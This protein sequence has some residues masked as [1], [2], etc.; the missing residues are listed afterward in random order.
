[1]SEVV[2]GRRRINGEVYSWITNTWTLGSHSGGP[3]SEYGA[4]AILDFEVR[5]EHDH[6]IARKV[7]PVQA[8]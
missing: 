5:D 3:E 4:D 1:M 2:K 8:K 7:L 6:V